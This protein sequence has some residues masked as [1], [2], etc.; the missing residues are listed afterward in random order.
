[1]KSKTLANVLIKILGLYICL[2]ALPSVLGDLIAAFVDV[3]PEKTGSV[4]WRFIPFAISYGVQ[5][6]C[7]IIIILSSRK[8]AGLLFREDEE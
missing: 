8:V 2:C 3:G 4:Y 1:M 5:L 7:G 6:I